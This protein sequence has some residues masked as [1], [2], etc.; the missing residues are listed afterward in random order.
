[1]KVRV[2]RDTMGE[3]KVPADRYY[4]A[5]TARSLMNFKI[6]GETMPPE[7]IRAMGILKKCAAKVNADLGLL[8]RASTLVCPD[9]VNRGK[10]HPE[11][12]QLACR[13]I[14][15]SPA[16]SVYIG[17]HRRDIE[18][19]KNA[20]MATIAVHY[21]YI[22]QQDPPGDWDADYE[23]QSV[24]QLIDWFTSVAVD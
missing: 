4:G 16:N 13:Q 7:L 5:Q 20:G 11:P 2:E 17:D 3:I 1:M 24:E 6:G 23:V 22:D 12:L 18:A 10:P 9:H 19:G 15:S 21:G 8:T 14:D